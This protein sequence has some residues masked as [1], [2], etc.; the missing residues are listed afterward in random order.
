MI[1]V[2]SEKNPAK[3]AKPV[4]ALAA[5]IDIHAWLRVVATN[6]TAEILSEASLL[7]D[8]QILQNINALSD[9]IPLINNK[10]N[11]LCLSSH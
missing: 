7:A 9:P 3:R 5:I 8:F 2:I 11:L 6:L 4:V 10:I 1:D